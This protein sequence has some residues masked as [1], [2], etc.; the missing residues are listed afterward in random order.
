MNN[1]KDK[2]WTILVYAN[3]NNDLEPEMWQAVLNITKVELNPVINVVIQ[4]GRA[5]KKL[6]KLLRKNYQQQNNENWNGVRRYSFEQNQLKLVKKLNRINMADP[7]TLF[8]F[9]NWGMQTYPA[10][11]YMLLVGGHGYQFVGSMPDY[12]Q[13]NPYIMGIPEMVEAINK[14]ANESGG[15]ID[16]L[17]LDICYFNFVEVIYE[18]GKDETHTVQNAI[19]Y[20]YTGPIEGLPYDKIIDHLQNKYCYEENRTVI[21]G[22]VDKLPYDLVGLEI[23]H[24]KLIQIKQRFN[25]LAINYCSRN[26]DVGKTDLTSILI[27][28]N[29]IVANILSLIIKYKRV[30]QTNNALIA[31]AT[32]ATGNLELILRYNKLSFAQ[33]NM[34]THLLSNKSFDVDTVI[35]R[36]SN[37]LPVKLKP[38]EVRAF[39]SIINPELVKEELNKILID[40]YS[41]RKWKFTM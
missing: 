22:L 20:I 10:K 34:W 37:L 33:Q 24:Q 4:I 39:I 15:K 31:I 2:E 14:G 3:G 18:L 11:R 5:D 23:N 28:E 41:Q 19:T 16:I 6:V 8:E 26:K 9:I 38:K 27:P 36:S 17:V 7:K 40:L 30:S 21:T 13:K 29:S 35:E 25:E 1:P 32:K 12:T